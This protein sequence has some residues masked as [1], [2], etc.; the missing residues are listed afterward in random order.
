MF[1]KYLNHSD[2]AVTVAYATWMHLIL[3]SEK[4]GITNLVIVL[5]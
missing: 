1:V 3:I 4:E 5:V 2:N